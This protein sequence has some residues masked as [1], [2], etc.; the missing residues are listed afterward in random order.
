MQTTEMKSLQHQLSGLR[1]E[2]AVSERLRIAMYSQLSQ[3]G[4]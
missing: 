3:K 1:V 4:L 2:M